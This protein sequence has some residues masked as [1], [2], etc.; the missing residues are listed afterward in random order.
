MNVAVAKQRNNV[1]GTPE[2]QR[3]LDER[4]LRIGIQITPVAR[5]YVQS[6]MIHETSKY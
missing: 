1:R 6:Y 5:K 3:E 4:I 2:K